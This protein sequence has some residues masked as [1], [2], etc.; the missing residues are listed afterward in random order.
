[1]TNLVLYDE[2]KI[3]L[4]FT[5]FEALMKYTEDE[6]KRYTQMETAAL[7]DLLAKLPPEESAILD[8]AIQSFIIFGCVVKS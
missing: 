2:V 6:L 8:F 3:A 1:M 4:K 5:H 7:Q